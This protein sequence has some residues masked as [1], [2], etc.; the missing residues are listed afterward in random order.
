[1]IMSFI[2]RRR[3][4]DGFGGG[5]DVN[6]SGIKRSRKQTRCEEKREENEGRN[7]GNGRR[8]WRRGIRWR[9]IIL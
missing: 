6:S 2:G 1:M 4:M 3:S 9:N 8:K 5:A 7:M